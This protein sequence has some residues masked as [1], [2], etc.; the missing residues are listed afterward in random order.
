MSRRPQV[1]SLSPFTPHASLLLLHC[2]P[3][4][5][6]HLLYFNG[7]LGRPLKSG[8]PDLNRRPSGPKPDALAR[9]RY[10]PNW[11]CDRRR[12]TK[13]YLSPLS[14]RKQPGCGVAPLSSPGLIVNA[15]KA[16]GL[17]PLGLE[18]IPCFIADGG[19]SNCMAAVHTPAITA[20]ARG[21]SDTRQLT[22]PDSGHRRHPDHTGTHAGARTPRGC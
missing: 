9:L 6:A 14:L 5:L 2:S 4:P 8:R 19:L 20:P 15:R 3:V 16:Q 18:R 1:R 7:R 21:R 17:Q 22:Q 12:T 13:P 11:W 10:A